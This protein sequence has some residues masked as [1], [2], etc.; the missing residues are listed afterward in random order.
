MMRLSI[1]NSVVLRRCLVAVVSALVSMAYVITG[2]TQVLHILTLLSNLICLFLQI[3]FRKSP[4]IIA[5][6]IVCF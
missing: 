5:A 6:L 3:M 2:L 4:D 1:F